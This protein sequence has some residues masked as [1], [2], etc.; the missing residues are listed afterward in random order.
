VFDLIA[1]TAKPE[2]VL[3]AVEANPAAD[4]TEGRFYANLYVGLNYEAEGDAAKSLAH[5]KTAAEKYVI[6]HYMWD[7]A[8]VHA[9]ARG[10]KK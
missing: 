10:P 7:V 1:G 5:V 3:A 2:D 6:G 8:K 9:A 4:K